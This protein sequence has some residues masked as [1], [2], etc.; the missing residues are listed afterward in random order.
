MTLV[1]YKL[2][3]RAKDILNFVSEEQHLHN[4]IHYKCS[5][6]IIFIIYIL[7]HTAAQDNS[8]PFTLIFT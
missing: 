2:S 4:I 7:F 5:V 6:L 3:I 1:E 8:S